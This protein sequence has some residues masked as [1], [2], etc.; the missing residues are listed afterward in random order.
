MTD[1]SGPSDPGEFTDPLENYEPKQYADAL[2]KALA[3]HTVAD[4]QHKPYVSIPPEMPVE[5][6]IKELAGLGVACLLVE[7]ETRL[8]G[9]FSDR[10]VVNKIALEYDDLKDR[11]V[12]EVMTADPVFVYESDSAA[13]ALSVMAVSGFRHVPVTD[14]KERVIGIVSPQ[15][16]TSFLRRHYEG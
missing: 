1:R 15:R 16:V 9:V 7:D 3:E 5:E 6:A 10:D 12:R 11:P 14:L 13:A 4:M 2:E 8:I